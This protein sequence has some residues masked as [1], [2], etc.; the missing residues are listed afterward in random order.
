LGARFDVRS[1]FATCE[2]D[3]ESIRFES[4]TIAIPVIPTAGNP[5][6]ITEM[7][8]VKLSA[9]SRIH[10]EEETIPRIRSEMTPIVSMEKR[11]DGSIPVL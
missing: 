4:E 9:N 6:T 8:D 5:E 10:R 7:I 1:G 11:S 2:F 3:R